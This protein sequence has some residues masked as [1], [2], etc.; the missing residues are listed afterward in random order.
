MSVEPHP[1]WT[2]VRAILSND[3]DPITCGVPE[4][5]YDG[6]VWP[7]IG[8][9]AGSDSADQIAD[10]LDWASNE[11]MQCPQPRDRNFLIALKLTALR[12]VC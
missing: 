3:W 6:Y 1:L 10:Y 5:E 11:H 12:S 4:D 8:K 2:Q 7:L 9:I